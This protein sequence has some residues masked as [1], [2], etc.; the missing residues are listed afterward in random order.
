MKNKINVEHINFPIAVQI[1]LFKGIG[2]FMAVKNRLKIFL[3]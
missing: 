2:A 1:N 3:L